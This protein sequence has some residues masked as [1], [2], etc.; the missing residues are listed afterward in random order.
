[1]PDELVRPERVVL[2]VGTREIVFVRVDDGRY[3]AEIDGTRRTIRTKHDSGW[4][5]EGTGGRDAGRCDRYR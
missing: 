4:V 2:A 3:A 1:M 5:S